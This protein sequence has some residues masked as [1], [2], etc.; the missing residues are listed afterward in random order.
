MKP[1]LMKSISK[2]VKGKDASMLTFCFWYALDTRACIGVQLLYCCRSGFFYGNY[3][4]F[5]RF[6]RNFL[7]SG[8]SDGFLAILRLSNGLLCILCGFQSTSY[9]SP[10]LTGFQDGLWGRCLF[11][12]PLITVRQRTKLQMPLE[13]W[14]RCPVK[15]EPRLLCITTMYL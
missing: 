11:P 9:F 8:T 10:I 7:Q 14:P 3:V 6:H 4:H 12:D 1:P 2:A 5:G 15:S 13:V